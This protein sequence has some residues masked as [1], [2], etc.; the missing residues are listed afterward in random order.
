MQDF[1]SKL[2]FV[3]STLN[4][5]IS[6]IT[7]P[8]PHPGVEWLIVHQ[9]V[10]AELSTRCKKV[11]SKFSDR[12]DV[13]YHPL[14]RKGLSYSRNYGLSKARTSYAYLLDDDVQLDA[15]APANVLTAINHYKA[16]VLTFLHTIG[17]Q[18]KKNALKKVTKHNWYTAGRVSSIDLCIN[19]DFIKRNGISFDESFG[20]GSMY[21][22]GEE[23]I[24]LRDCLRA[25]GAV[26][27]V[28]EIVAHHPPITSGTD[29]F[30]C[31][32]YV[33]AKRKMFQR[34]THRKISFELLA[35]YF[36]KLPILLKARRL[37]FFTI[38]YFGKAL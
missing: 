23:Y 27:H 29:F 9:I 11:V 5:R 19:L 31:V 13:A 14:C 36:K 3:Y 17:G 6:E 26:V 20:L 34:A 30:S 7:L 10:G 28:P 24:F 8:P 4:D 12:E 37:C 22:S 16:D 15:N 21:P 33:L 38:H 32:D 2:T 35:F 25:H 1:N 18:L